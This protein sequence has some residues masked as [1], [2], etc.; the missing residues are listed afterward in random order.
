MTDEVVVEIT[1]RADV[2]RCGTAARQVA[3]RVGFERKRQQELAIIVQ[4]LASNI[5]KFAGTGI[6]RI[7]EIARPRAGIE[8]QAEDQGP[9]IEDVE[10]A[11]RDGHTEGRDRLSRPRHSRPS[12]GVGLGAV[13]RLADDLSITSPPGEGTLVVVRCFL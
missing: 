11:L 5:L 7:R 8:V 3:A 12:L 4:E 2:L 6:V 10:A 1:L 13:Q 9:G